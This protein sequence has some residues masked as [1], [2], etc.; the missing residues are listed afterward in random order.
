MTALQVQRIVRKWKRR[1]DLSEWRFKVQIVSPEVLNGKYGAD[2][3]IYADTEPVLSKHRALIRVSADTP[4]EL[5]DETIIHELGHALFD[6]TSRMAGDAI[7]E[8]GL[9]RFA[10]ALSRKP[11]AEQ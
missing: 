7:F 1:L 2:Y 8:T 5:M 10:R 4:K 11:K 9:D 6:P 3:V